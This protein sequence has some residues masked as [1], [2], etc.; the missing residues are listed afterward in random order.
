MWSGYDGQKKLE[1]VNQGGR[2]QIVEKDGKGKEEKDGSS[3]S[4]NQ[5]T[6]I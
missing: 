1:D 6:I 5:R 2:S 4:I 3:R